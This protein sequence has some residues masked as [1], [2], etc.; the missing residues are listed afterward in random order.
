MFLS[1]SAKD[2]LQNRPPHA[3][4]KA[5]GRIEALFMQSTWP[6]W[7]PPAGRQAAGRL[8]SGPTKLVKIKLQ[9]WICSGSSQNTERSYVFMS[10]MTAY[11][12]PMSSWETAVNPS[13]KTCIL[14][15]SNEKAFQYYL[16]NY[17]IKSK[18]WILEIFNLS[19]T[20]YIKR[21][22]EFTTRRLRSLC[23]DN[24][25]KSLNLSRIWRF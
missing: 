25:L 13:N 23:W 21:F 1:S 5:V 9:M 20:T 11:V 14:R 6:T 18:S 12:N 10:T 24:I 15:L 8:K 2:K 16:I 4:R 19:L 22:Y 3:G 7:S 17:V